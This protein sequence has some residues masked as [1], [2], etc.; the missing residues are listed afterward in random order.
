MTQ[1]DVCVVCNQPML[2]VEPN[3]ITHPCCDPDDTPLP[4]LNI[5]E[6]AELLGD[7]GRLRQ[8]PGRCTCCG[9]YPA[10]QGHAAD[11]N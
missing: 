1:L 6:I 11:C 9:Y 10:T 8:Q 2:A 5:N 3:Q 7:F 4:A